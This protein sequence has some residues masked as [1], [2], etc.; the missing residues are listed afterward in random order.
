MVSSYPD[1]LKGGKSKVD[2]IWSRE[3]KSWRPA[4]TQ[5]TETWSGLLGGSS[6]KGDKQIKGNMDETEIGVEG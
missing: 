5:P 4:N 6:P 3:L 1:S 2:F